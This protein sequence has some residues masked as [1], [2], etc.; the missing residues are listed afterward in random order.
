MPGPVIVV[1]SL[2]AD[3]VVQ[4]ERMPDRGET[5]MG[6]D[7]QHHPG[8][9]GLNQAVAAARLGAD[10]HMVGAVGYDDAGAM[11]RKVT[12]DEGI[13]DSHLFTMEGP[14]G[15]ALI[16]VET[17]GANRIV[18]ISGAN[19]RLAPQNVTTAI[20]AV[21]APAVVLA[22]G[23]VPLPAIEAAMAAGRAAGAITI[24]NPAPALAFPDTL[25]ANVDVIVPNEHEA[26]ILTGLP[27]DTLVD[28]EEAAATFNT[29]GVPYAVITRGSH[30]SVWSSAAHGAG[31]VATH[32]VDAI[33]TVAA[34]D[35][36][37]GALA[38]ALA[39]GRSMPE[40]L[41]WAAAAGALA[42]TV[43]GAVPSL[44]R[45]SAVEALLD[46]A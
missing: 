19:G 21:A 18:V 25:L 44:P 35:A 33:D 36:F 24:L 13:D 20:Q 2:N 43:M 27:T 7:V 3:I 29:K 8:G 10:V 1:G 14:S 22:Q 38:A 42:T 30:G 40:A 41:R 6:N 28:A 12:V 31:S 34:G 15:T 16:E 46:N 4:L 45:R 26:A 9:K 17:N 5:V 37:C 23:E 39:E 32:P 11:L